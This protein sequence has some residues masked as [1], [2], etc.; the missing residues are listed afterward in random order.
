MQKLMTASWK[1]R[2]IAYRKENAN[3]TAFYGEWTSELPDKLRYKYDFKGVQGNLPVITAINGQKAWRS[4]GDGRGSEDLEDKRLK[5]EQEEV[6][7][8]YI[9]RL[10]PLLQGECQL[11]SMPLGKRDNRYVLGLKVDKQDR[12]TNRLYFDRKLGLLSYMERSVFDVEQKKDVIQETRFEHFQAM[13]G[14]LLPQSITIKRDG[15][16]FLE[17]EINKVEPLAAVD[18]K[19]FLKPPEPKSP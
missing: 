10:V 19:L 5:D 11:T 4:F 18:D 9:S 13:G 3:G 12:R 8:L 1:G 2:G 17:L 6:F 14:A 16:L 15:K 7:S